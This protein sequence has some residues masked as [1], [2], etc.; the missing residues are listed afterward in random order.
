MTT[1][2]TTVARAYAELQG[3]AACVAREARLARLEVIRS[4]AGELGDHDRGGIALLRLGRIRQRVGE[5]EFAIEMVERSI[6]QAA[7]RTATG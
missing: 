2:L 6:R 5:V 1:D 3:W 7:V 4:V